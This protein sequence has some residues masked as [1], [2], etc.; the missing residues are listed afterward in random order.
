MNISF[1][2]KIAFGIIAITLSLVVVWR[3]EFKTQDSRHQTLVVSLQ[4]EL[5]QRD[6]LAAVLTE[7]DKIRTTVERISAQGQVDASVGQSLEQ[8]L[9]SILASG[10]KIFTGADNPLK[11]LSADVEEFSKISQQ[12]SLYEGKIQE[13]IGS[14]ESY[15]RTLQETAGRWENSTTAAIAVGGA[16]TNTVPFAELEQKISA[17][18]RAIPEFSTFKQR[19]QG[20][21]IGFDQWVQDIN[22]VESVEEKQAVFAKKRVLLKGIPELSDTFKKYIQTASARE[23]ENVEQIALQ[24]TDSLAETRNQVQDK[25]AVKNNA[26]QTIMAQTKYKDEQYRKVKYAVAGLTFIALIVFFFAVTIYTFRFEKGL[27]FFRRKT[28]EAV[29]TTREVTNSLKDNSDLAVKNFNLT[30]TL[31]EGLS[32]VS[33]GFLARQ[34]NLQQIDQQLRDTDALIKESQENFIHIKEE[35]YNAEKISK[36]IV[37]LT[38]AL[39][40][41]AQQMTAVAERVASDPMPA[42][43]KEKTIDELKYLSGRIRFAVNATHATLDGR[44]AKI[45]EAKAKFTLIENNMAQMTENTKQS[46]RS[47]AL[48][49][50]DHSEE[51]NRVNEILENARNTSRVIVTEIETLNKQIN[52]FS[53]LSKH[54]AALH[55][56]AVKASALN[57]QSLLPQEEAAAEV[58]TSSQRMNTYVQEYFQKIFENPALKD[59][60]IAPVDVS[61]SSRVQAAADV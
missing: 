48:T 21:A 43:G 36:E 40:G 9:K 60:A 31:K 23:R 3:Y 24:I 18:E 59:S 20:L 27:A 33:G 45:E 56:L 57:A 35:V 58:V 38:G 52:D 26:V 5:R 49:R 29:Q 54:L 10:D 13:F 7:M 16:V 41:V 34:G 6:E 47:L 2:H 19:M 42:E 53:A 4:N 12:L 8:S 61:K 50:L 28:Y 51:V 25:F 55:E 37:N 46:L 32:E 11:Q 17:L 44:A 1:H 39:E 15:F 30:Q 14:F 22:A